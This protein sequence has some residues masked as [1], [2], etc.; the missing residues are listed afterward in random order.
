[1]KINYSDKKLKDF[2]ENLDKDFL[3]K[4]YDDAVPDCSDSKK[5]SKPQLNK[6]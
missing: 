2:F 1:M 5:S 3:K 6:G 4:V